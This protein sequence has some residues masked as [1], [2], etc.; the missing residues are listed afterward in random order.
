MSS[1]KG[2]MLGGPGGKLVFCPTK[3]GWR[4]PENRNRRRLGGKGNCSGSNFMSGFHKVH[5]KVTKT[6]GPERKVRLQFWEGESSQMQQDSG[7]VPGMSSPYQISGEL[8]D[9]I[10]FTQMGAGSGKGGW[11]KERKL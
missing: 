11:E 10:A 4:V 3:T 9:M 5:T 2:L 1:R 6:S 7:T 8:I